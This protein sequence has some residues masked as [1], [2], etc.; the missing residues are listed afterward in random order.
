MVIGLS[1]S[2]GNH[3]CPN[4]KSAWFGKSMFF[5]DSKGNTKFVF[6]ILKLKNQKKQQHVIFLIQNNVDITKLPL[7]FLKVHSEGFL[8]GEEPTES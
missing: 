1:N 4:F 3:D 6:L 7:T 8:F 5:Y 2:S